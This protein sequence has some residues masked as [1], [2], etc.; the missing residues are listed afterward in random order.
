[1]LQKLIY[2]IFTFKTAPNTFDCSLSLHQRIP[3]ATT[4]E[5]KNAHINKMTRFAGLR[6][7]T[8]NP[9]T[10]KQIILFPVDAN[11]ATLYQ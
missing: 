2:K 7:A 1:M 11:P 3:I 10:S 4:I 8:F 6:L 9:K 5:Q